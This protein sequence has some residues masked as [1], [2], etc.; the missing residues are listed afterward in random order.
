MSSAIMPCEE[1][2]EILRPAYLPCCEFGNCSEARWAPQEGHVPR[3]YLGATTS[4]EDVRLVI[5][6]AEPGNPQP[7]E[8]Y[9]NERPD[10]MIAAVTDTA[11]RCFSNGQDVFHRNVCWFLSRRFS[12][13]TFDE[14]LRHTWL[15]E[16]RLCSFAKETGG[17][18]DRRCADHYLERQ[19][20]ALPNAQIVAAGGKAQDYLTKLKRDFISCYAFAPPGANTK[21]ARWSWETA[22]S[23]LRV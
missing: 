23:N 10:N 17:R 19:L 12:S 4:A 5:V 3:G 14:Q 11:Y 13:L 2:L 8:V 9:S 22:L 16:G 21:K 7:S 6:F 18:K 15:T 20:D 1:L